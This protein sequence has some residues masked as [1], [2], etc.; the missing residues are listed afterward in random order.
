M[1]DA[2]QVLSGRV[3]EGTDVGSPRLKEIKKDKLAVSGHGQKVKK[4]LTITVIKGHC[5]G[6]LCNICVAYCPEKVLAMGFR[7]VEVVN[8]D[9]CTKCML[10]EIR[11]PDFAI[12]VD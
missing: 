10:C 5:K 8:A 3:E 7:H 2:L 6:S 1:A 9:A 4:D 12:F 11:C